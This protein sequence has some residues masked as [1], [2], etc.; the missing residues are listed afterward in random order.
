[1]ESAKALAERVPNELGLI[2]FGQGRPPAL[3][4][5]KYKE[6]TAHI[7]EVSSTNAFRATTSSLRPI[8]YAWLLHNV[9]DQI[10]R[11]GQGGF[12]LCTHYLTRLAKDAGL[13]FRKPF[14][15]QRKAPADAEKQIDDLTLRMAYL[16]KEHNIPPSRVLNA[17]HTGLHFT[18]QRGGTWMEL[19]EDTSDTHASRKGKLK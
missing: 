11:P 3:P 12:S 19:E 13:H 15:D 7:K 2:E 18:Q 10:F 8:A 4:P 5:D 6:L 9:G 16:M 17:D 14:G 1:M